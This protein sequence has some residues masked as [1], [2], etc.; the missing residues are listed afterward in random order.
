[1]SECM[2]AFQADAPV[3]LAAASPEIKLGDPIAN[4]SA[5]VSAIKRAEKAEADYLVLPELFLCG[6]TLGSLTEHPLILSQCREALSLVAEATKHNQLLVSIGLPYRIDGR[7][8]SCIALIR[9]GRVCAVIPA[10]RGAANPFGFIPH[11]PGGSSSRSTLTP[12]PRLSAG[13]AGAIFLE[14]PEPREGHIMLLSGSLNATAKSYGIIKDRLAAYSARTGMA[15]A[16]ALPGR[17][18][19]TTS[20]VFDSYCAIAANGEILAESKPLDPDAFVCADVC[21]DKLNS[22]EP[23]TEGEEDGYVSNNPEKAECQLRRLFAL[24]SAG[25]VRRAEHIGAKGFVI[26][27]SGGLDSALALLVACAAADEMGIG[28]GMITGIS[29]PGFGTT[30]R[31]K[32]NSRSLVE[33]LGCKYREISVANACRGHFADIGH[34]ENIRNSVY[35]NAQAR[36]RTQILLDIANEEGLLDVGTG[37]LSEAALGWTTFGGD[38]LAQYGVN[39]SVPKTII[40]RV[41]ATV[42]KDFGDEADGVLKDILATPVSPELLPANDG[43]ISQKTEEL[44]GSYDLHDLFI[45]YFLKG[46]GPRELYDIALK[47]LDFPEDEVYRTLGIF[48]KRFFSQ[49]FKR[50]C[51]PEAPIVCLSVAP[52]VWSMPSDMVSTAFMAEYSAIKRKLS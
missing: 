31:T 4:A 10:S 18:E 27:V 15:V 35:E 42:G 24:Q 51:A 52:A 29:M 48:I 1:M 25:L 13:F 12:I 2:L 23:F 32:N 33:A 40:R 19:S 6:A 14:K 34:D 41:V 16:L 30:G 43:E 26:G 5:A 8:R 21:I 9:C 50:N 7:V 37:D 49:Q 38:H 47:S 3:R 22:F 46:K 36:E 17:G 28:R 44:V 45:Y 39:A 11:I 20:F